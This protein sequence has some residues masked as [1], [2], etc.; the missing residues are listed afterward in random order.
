LINFTIN[1]IEFI[2]A[3]GRKGDI[4]MAEINPPNFA[5]FVI[6]QAES[7]VSHWGEHWQIQPDLIELIFEGARKLK[8]SGVEVR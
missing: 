4:A 2:P 5:I 8:E 6:A 7:D 3:V 1:R